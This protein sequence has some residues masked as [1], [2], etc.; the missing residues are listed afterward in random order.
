MEKEDRGNRGR[1]R[2][3]E[4]IL[5]M[6]HCRIVCTTG[7]NEENIISDKISINFAHHSD[8]IQS[9]ESFTFVVSS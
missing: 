1:E 2:G 9:V 8:T 4:L 5:N 3:R 7:L 6:V